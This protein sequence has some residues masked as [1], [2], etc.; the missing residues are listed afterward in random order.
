MQEPGKFSLKITVIQ[1]GIKKY[2][3]FIVKNKLNY[4][5]S[6]QFLSSLLESFF[7]NLIENNFKYLS[8]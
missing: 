2:T 7:K 6:F 1:N 4:I 3:S 5:D 8:Q